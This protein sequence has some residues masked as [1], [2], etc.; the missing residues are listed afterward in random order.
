MDAVKQALLWA[1]IGAAASPI[2]GTLLWLFWEGGLRPHLVP[3]TEIDS[4]AARMVARHGRSA[5]EAAYLEEEY[6]WRSS[7]LFER[8]KWR[9]VRRRI[10]Q[11]RREGL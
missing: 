7:R 10:E 4:L 6:A 8:G 2:W 11:K 3:R 9:R 1:G 5:E